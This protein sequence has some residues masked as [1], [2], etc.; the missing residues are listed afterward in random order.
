MTKDKF[1]NKI[2]E[3][4]FPHYSC[5]ICGKETPNGKLCDGCKEFLIVPNYCA[6]CGEHVGESDTLCLECSETNWNFDKNVSVFEYNQFTASPILAMKYKEKRYLAKDFA[7]LLY[8]RY[9]AAGFDAEIV[10]SVP[11]SPKRL[12]ERGYNHAEDLAKEFCK[13]AN[14]PYAELLTKT[15]ETEHQTELAREERKQN[16]VD[17][18]VCTDKTVKGKKVLIIDDVFTTGSTLDA[19]SKAIK[20]CKPSNIYCLTIA[21]TLYSKV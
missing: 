13:L 6:R 1:W 7:K 8:E 4:L 5:A 21:K 20:K 12:K 15:K 14:L 18:F 3:T 17:A 19:C 2:K 9:V 11:S 16:L 10:C